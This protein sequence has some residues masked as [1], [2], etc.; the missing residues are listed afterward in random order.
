MKTLKSIAGKN[1][2]SLAARLAIGTALATICFGYGGRGAYAGSCVVDGGAGTYLCSGVAGADITQTLNSA[3][4]TV[5]TSD[6]F[7]ITAATGDALS[8]DSTSGLSFTDNFASSISGA[9][10]GIDA[11][12]FGTGALSIT[13]SGTVTATSVDGIRANQYSSA[14]G[15][16][17]TAT[18]QVTGAGAGIYAANFSATGMTVS[19]T[20]VA[21]GFT[22]IAVN[23]GA[24]AV[25]ITTTGQATGTT[26]DGISATTQNDMT[27]SV[28][29]VSGGR[30]G[31]Y[32]YHR[33]T[34]AASISVSG[35]VTGGSVAGIRSY[36]YGYNYA[37]YG[38]FPVGI[39]N[40]I[41]ITLNSGAS[42]SATSGVAINDDSG[43]AAVLVNS[44]A[45]VTGAITLASGTDSVTFDGGDFS[46]VTSFD[47]GSGNDDS[48]TL[49][50]VVATVTGTD[51]STKVTGME[52]L[53]F[54]TGITVTGNVVQ[55]AE[56]NSLT[57]DGA[58]FTGVTSFDGGAGTDSLTFSNFTGTLAGGTVTNMENV[59]I[60]S[61]GSVALSG[62][63]DVTTVTVENGGTL[64]GIATVNAAVSVNGGGT[65][66]AGNSPGLLSIVGDLDLGVSSTTLVELG[67]LI[68]GTEYDQIDVS[69]D[70]GTGGTVEGI[71]TLAAGAIF[72][73][74]FFGAFTAS[75]GDSFDVLIADDIVGDINTLLFDFTG[76]APGLSWST[77]L[78]SFTG[79]AN[80]G[81]EA[82]RL[83]V[84]SEAIAVP[85]P[86]TLPLFASLL[87]L[88]GLGR[89]RRRR[90]AG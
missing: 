72:N 67:G 2:A 85:E 73:I 70:P 14:G 9:E 80:D 86:S 69:D 82:L 66:S 46:G 55:G 44:G 24:G 90:K 74:D 83:T 58:D 26:G 38:G 88:I 20:D 41:D 12:N 16:N 43:N 56:D 27:I 8:L 57:L 81:R 63:L 61:G 62:A 37:A 75:L 17:I 19:A 60:G 30:S 35:T 76:T 32:A 78:F 42:V 23:N 18:G 13:T 36:N 40:A 4:L 33:G 79:G 54:G 6:P 25:S 68:A 49:R 87:G 51:I 22:G 47:G 31:I 59:T 29:D 77:E 1:Q 10:R 52:N 3:S 7:G 89:A 48:L 28:V 53:T 71:A 64:G 84:I 11:R 65:L 5:T 39:R 34:G 50:N 45:S 21:G 15:L